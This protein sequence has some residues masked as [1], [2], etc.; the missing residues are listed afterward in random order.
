MSNTSLPFW[1]DRLLNDYLISIANMHLDQRVVQRVIQGQIDVTSRNKDLHDA[2]KSIFDLD[3]RLVLAFVQKN[4]FF[5]S[6]SKSDQ[7]KL[8]KR[9]GPLFVQYLLARYL[10]AW[11]GYDQL[12]VLL[13][14]ILPTLCNIFFSSSVRITF[15]VEFSL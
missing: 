13:G 9:N 7:R 14:P 4:P 5:Q 6:L 11:T 3:Q 8:Y 1:R 15:Q 2:I 12:S 10:S